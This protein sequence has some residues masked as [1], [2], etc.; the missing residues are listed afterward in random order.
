M[1]FS[2]PRIEVNVDAGFAKIEV[3]RINGKDGKVG[4]SWNT[5]EISAKSNQH[6]VDTKGMVLFDDGEDLQVIEVPLISSSKFE[7]FAEFKIVLIEPQGYC[8]LGNNQECYVRLLPPTSTSAGQCMSSVKLP[9]NLPHPTSDTR[10]DTSPPGKPGQLRYEKVSNSS[11]RLFWTEPNTGEI[12]AYWVEYYQVNNKTKTAVVVSLKP[13]QKSLLVEN[14]IE[15]TSYIFDVKA[16][17]QWGFS[18]SRLAR[19]TM[20]E[21][22]EK[23]DEPT[24]IDQAADGHLTIK[25]IQDLLDEN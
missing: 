20:R 19:G 17:N 21:R 10:E 23:T 13:N 5:M 11:I 2:L 15:N 8:S 14:L 18:E 6:F 9:V 4:C 1:T 3:K 25:Q 24:T 12:S 7:E 22:E 16:E